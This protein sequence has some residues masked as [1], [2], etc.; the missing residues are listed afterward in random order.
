MQM[1]EAALHCAVVGVPFSKV[2][3]V[4]K[5]VALTGGKPIT[6][7]PFDPWSVR[8]PFKV[9]LTRWGPQQC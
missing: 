3:F 6:D 5:P 4:F 7:Q 2:A 9:C 1:R 8:N